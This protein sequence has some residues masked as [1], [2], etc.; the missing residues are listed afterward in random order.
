MELETPI[1]NLIFTKLDVFYKKLIRQIIK[2]EIKDKLYNN[3]YPIWFFKGSY[4]VDLGYIIKLLRSED[5]EPIRLNIRNM[6]IDNLPKY[7][8]VKIKIIKLDSYLYTYKILYNIK[9]SSRIYDESY[10]IH[11][12]ACSDYI[13]DNSI[14]KIIENDIGNTKILLHLLDNIILPQFIKHIESK[15]K[16][17]TN[18]YNSMQFTFND[19]EFVNAHYINYISTSLY[20]DN[21][22]NMIYGKD[23]Y[24]TGSEQ[25]WIFNRLYKM[26][27]EHFNEKNIT[28][29]YIVNMDNT[30]ILSN[31][32]CCIFGSKQY[33]KNN[34]VVKVIL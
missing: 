21:N 17:Y 22:K 19:N 12:I 18:M 9:L 7:S 15:I 10:A 6:L 2:E 8:V 28:I 23:G 16:F 34:T 3:I 24:Y 32:F 30:F 33:I 14:N 5:T 1:D 27:K 11:K 26:A 29:N 20:F 25:T 13:C 4:S 31:I